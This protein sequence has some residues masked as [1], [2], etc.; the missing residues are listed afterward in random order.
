[1]QNR[2]IRTVIYDY[3]S[4]ASISH[5]NLTGNDNES[6]QKGWLFMIFII[7][8]PKKCKIHMTKSEFKDPEKPQGIMK[9]SQ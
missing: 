6:L 9:T 2:I 7:F 8:P 4:E 1:M 3:S 5:E